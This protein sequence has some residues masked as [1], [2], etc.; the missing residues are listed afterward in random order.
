MSIYLDIEANGLNPDTIWCVVT[1]DN[2]KTREG[3]TIVHTSP[4]TLQEALR[5][6]MSVVGHNLIG[7]DLP[8]LK[9]L[10]GVS[11]EPERVIDTLVLS[12]L[13]NPSRE[14]GHSLRSWGER[15]G[16]PKGDYSDWSKLTQ[17]MIDY[18]I[19]DVKVTEHTHFKLMTEMREFS[20]GSIDLEHKVQFI[21]QQQIRNG[22]LLDERQAFDLLAQLKEKQYDLEEKVQKTFRPIPV[23]VKSVQPR[24]KKDGALS[25]VGLKFLGDSW[26]DVC[27]EF[28]RIESVPFNLAS[29]KQIGVH[30]KR[31]GWKPAKFTETGQPIVDEATLSGVKGI[32]EA[33]MIAEYLLVQ[34]RIA[35]VQSWV[36]A[37]GNDGRVRGFVNT[38]GAVT[39]RMTHSKP[40]LAQT[41]AG[42]SPFGKECRS[43]WTVPEGRKLVGVDA[44]GL[45]LR[46]L[47]HY[48]NDSDYTE[49]IINGDIHSANQRAAGLPDR[50]TSKTFIYAFLYGAGDEKL[51][52]L[53]GGRRSRGAELRQR[54]LASTPALADL[55]KRVREKGGEGTLKGLDGRLLQVRS[56][57]SSLNTLL[58]AAGA[59]VMKQALILLEQ[60]AVKWKIN[61]KFV[62]NIHDEIQTEVQ[63][64]QADKFGH[65]AVSCIEAAGLHFNLRCPLTGDYYV[66]SNWSQT[67]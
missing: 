40:N 19:Q 64:D 22:W 38:N 45:E 21:I 18:C 29:R 49:E 48:M 51:G 61:Y 44:S 62:G 2:C 6:R 1:K 23:Y 27:G 30:L 12:R 14:G 65:L 17:E 35:Q 3:T 33:Q 26:Q 53:V 66:G 25:S 8:V 46:M 50:D 55:Q 20:Q 9:S 39:G 37:M 52:K 10:W 36:D 28:S 34:K 57:H 15:L 67:H 11:V 63:A 32:P 60:Y 59:I 16:F 7:Y 31:F 47:A 56:E 54:F 13:S 42:Y 4:D 43:C 58:Q 41:P 24:Y 5:G